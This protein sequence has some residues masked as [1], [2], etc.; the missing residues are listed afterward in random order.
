M[1]P[2]VFAFAIHVSKSGP[3]S[4]ASHVSGVLR[5]L[6]GPQDAI[7]TCFSK[8]THAQRTLTFPGSVL[9]RTSSYVFNKTHSLAQIYACNPHPCTNTW[10]C[11]IALVQKSTRAVGDSHNQAAAPSMSKQHSTRDVF[12]ETAQGLQGQT[13][14]SFKL[15]CILSWPQIMLPGEMSK[16]KYNKVSSSGF[17]D[18][19]VVVFGD[20]TGRQNVISS[21]VCLK[22]KLL[23]RYTTDMKGFDIQEILK[24]NILN[25][26]FEK[27]KNIIYIPGQKQEIYCVCLQ[28]PFI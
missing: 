9:T 6:S 28:L 4:D 23:H 12:R 10:L 22:F 14:V 5:R 26:S 1:Q 17:R 15:P 7:V 25:S 24:I 21:C 16:K 8:H 11:L 3:R 2:D 13:V 27:K 19:L 18:I 20:K